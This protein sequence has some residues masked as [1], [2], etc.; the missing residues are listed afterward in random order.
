MATSGIVKGATSIPLSVISEE[1]TKTYNYVGNEIVDC[2]I[3]SFCAVYNSVNA[4][5]NYI[6]STIN[7]VSM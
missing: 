5:A 2:H 1:L 4:F 6:E 7:N 3:T